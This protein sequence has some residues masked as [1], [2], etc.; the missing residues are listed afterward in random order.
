V[1]KKSFFDP[2]RAAHHHQPFLYLN[3]ESAR[4]T[5]AAAAEHT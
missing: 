2:A 1:G 5:V 4:V 3:P